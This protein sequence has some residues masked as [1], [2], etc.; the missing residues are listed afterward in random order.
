MRKLIAL[1]ML[2]YSPQ[3]A[4]P[5]TMA[6]S[7][8]P[9]IICYAQFGYSA[10]TAFRIGP[11]T[12]LSVNHVTKASR[13]YIEGEPIHV[14][15]ASAKTD[16]SMLSDSRKG[17]WLRVDCGG[18]VR[19]RTYVAVGH[20][21]AMDQLL[22][23]EMTATGIV[24]DGIAVL[25]GVL[26]AQPGQSGGPIIDEETGAVVG[27]VNA[28]DWA[29]GLSFSVDYYHVKIGNAINTFGGSEANIVNTCYNVVKNVSDPF[30]QAIHRNTST[31]AL[32]GPIQF[33]VSEQLANIAVIKTSGIDVTA[34]YQ[35]HA[36]NL[37]YGLSFAGTYVRAYDVQSDPTSSFYKCAGRFS[38]QCNSNPIPHWK[39][40]AEL[41]L[42]VGDVSLLT[43]WRYIGAVKDDSP[44]DAGLAV[45][46]IKAFNYFDETASVDIGK[47]MT[48]RLGIQNL[49]DKK[50]PIVGDTIGIDYTSGSTFPNVYDVLGRTFFTSV[51]VKF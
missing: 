3:P 47:R 43:R 32:S 40:D 16:F 27:T 46:R 2:V 23:V 5:Q 24:K 12:L 42:G 11:T 34:G 21:R 14:T 50:P 36:G 51:S 49:F 4:I 29:N 7:P 22:R 38:S 25:S 48:L 33:G 30:C 44:Q 17:N 26:E 15:Y 1:S 39:H 28:A 18:F 19:G 41:T 6:A 9:K 31:G 10:G 13:C 20:A 35:G 37:T 8:V 45:S